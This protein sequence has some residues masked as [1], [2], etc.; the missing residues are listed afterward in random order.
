MQDWGAYERSLT[1][2]GITYR[3]DFYREKAEPLPEHVFY[4]DHV[5]ATFPCCYAESITPMDLFIY[6]YR[7]GDCSQSVSR[8]NQLK[9]HAHM[10][11]VLRVME[12]RY[13]EMSDSPNRMYVGKKLEC[14]LLSYFVTTLLA[15]S[16]RREGRMLAGRELG[17]C[18]ASAP[19]V[20][21]TLQKKYA[22]F[23]FMNRLHMTDASWGR[24]LESSLYKCI[25]RKRSFS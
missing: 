10:E 17:R 14:V 9:R 7:I 16:D 13:A 12:Q 6:E 4:E 11:T 20:A 25:M 22:F 8:Q 3:T 5:Y 24:I 18:R 23:H 19:Q 21:S 1:F 2:H 15:D